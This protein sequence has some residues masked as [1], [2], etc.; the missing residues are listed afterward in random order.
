MNLGF[1]VIFISKGISGGSPQCF[2]GVGPPRVLIWSCHRRRAEPQVP[3]SASCQLR[4][5]APPGARDQ[6]RELGLSAERR[7]LLCPWTLS[8]I[9]DLE[10]RITSA[11]APSPRLENKN[12]QSS[13][14]NLTGLGLQQPGAPRGGRRLVRGRR[15]VFRSHFST[16]SE[17]SL[18]D[19]G[20]Q[21]KA[22]VSQSTLSPSCPRAGTRPV[23]RPPAPQAEPFPSE[24]AP[25]VPL[26]APQPRSP[27][28][29]VSKPCPRLRVVQEPRAARM[30][31]RPWPCGAASSRLLPWKLDLW[32]PSGAFPSDADA[33]LAG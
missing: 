15:R 6:Y 20:P 27:L 19:Q 10:Y 22:P 25:S 16:R 17:G 23:P 13:N 5:T 26:R 12:K 2:S 28:G 11:P 32:G 33:T 1:N 8:L 7:P 9:C 21:Q 29:R 3:G 14:P 4:G 24:G 18:S 31:E 30:P